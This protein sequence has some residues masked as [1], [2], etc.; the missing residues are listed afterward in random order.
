MEVLT[1]LAAGGDAATIALVVFLWKQ[2]RRI[3]RME[4]FLSFKFNYRENVK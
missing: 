2:D 4:Q 1:A 3:F